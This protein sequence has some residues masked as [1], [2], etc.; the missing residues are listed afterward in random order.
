MI[1]RV[2][3]SRVTH[4]SARIAGTVIR[5][6]FWLMS[7]TVQTF[8]GG[9]CQTN[10]YLLEAEGRR[11]LIDAP[12]DA[13]D[14]LAGRG[15]GVDALLLTHQHFDHVLDAARIKA[16]HGCEIYA[17]SPPSP[18]LWLNRLFSSATGWALDVPEYG[19]DHLLDGR[20][21]LSVAGFVFE[22]L[23]VP[24][25]SPDSVCFLHT[26][27]QQC[28]C[29]DTVF[30]LGIG[31]TDFPGGSHAQ[32]VAGIRERILAL[33]DAVALLPGHGPPTT[34]GSEKRVNSFLRVA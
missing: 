29:G 2:S 31:R 19:V 22:L 3:G 17:W 30:R 18:D 32:L 21:Q 10:A 7:M 33:P 4:N 28:F 16:E 24:G 1:R 23:H 26:P 27:T 6:S 9:V 20:E 13:A 15:V 14:W 11:V 12:D 25:H 34:V 5:I 8:T